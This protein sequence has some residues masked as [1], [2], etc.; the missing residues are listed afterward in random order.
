M[1][2]RARPAR[3]GGQRA[4]QREHP[5]G[6]VHQEDRPP[7]GAEQVGLGQRATQQRA[8]EP[9]ERERARVPR[10]RLRPLPLVELRVDER[11]DL[12]HHQPGPDAL[13]HACGD[14][15][16]DVPGET[17][18][19]RRAREHE[20]ARHEQ[21]LRPMA[22]TQPASG[23]QREREAQCVTGRNPLQR[24][25]AGAELPPDGGQR[26]RHDLVVDHVHQDRQHRDGQRPPPQRVLLHDVPLSPLSSGHSHSQPDEVLCQLDV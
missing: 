17:R 14:Q 20:H 15:H 26:H 2:E 6:Q 23:D 10:H 21:L 25:L 3:H 24:R 7:A 5:D 16:A 8:G 12:R 4:D 9:A 18:G 19:Q 1:P 13:H 22:V 11:Q